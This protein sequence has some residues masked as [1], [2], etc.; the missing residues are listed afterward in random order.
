MTRYQSL[1]GEFARRGFDSATASARV[2]E[3]WERRVDGDPPVDLAIFEPVADRDLALDSLERMS[4]A[5]P[6]LFARIAAD[7]G[8][9]HRVVMVLGG[10]SAL[11]QTLVRH[12]EEAEALREPPQPR[13]RDGWREFFIGRVGLEDG[14]ARIEKLR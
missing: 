1:T 7:E 5:A 10:S 12:P 6:E 9:L 2:W 13:G 3:R 11:A 14:V 4:E 8:W